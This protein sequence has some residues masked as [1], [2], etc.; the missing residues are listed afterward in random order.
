RLWRLPSRG[1]RVGLFTGWRVHHRTIALAQGRV[2]SPEEC[3]VS[4][5]TPILIHT[6]RPSKPRSAA[7][8]R[9][10]PTIATVYVIRLLREQHVLF[11][12]QSSSCAQQTQ[13][14]RRCVRTRAASGT[15]G[16]RRSARP[17][18]TVRWPDRAVRQ[19]SDRRVA[20]G[21]R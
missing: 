12:E 14:F 4:Y 6:G 21:P 16:N 9:G 10:G 1:C 17:A 18:G 2:A 3:T 20:P 13:Q 5:L 11:P 19:G 8:A 7:G 15:S